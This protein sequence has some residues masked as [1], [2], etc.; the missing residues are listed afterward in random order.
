[1]AWVHC[2]ELG[3]VM[4]DGHEVRGTALRIDLAHDLVLFQPMGSQT[5]RNK[6]EI[7]LSNFWPAD[8][9]AFEKHLHA[10]N[11]GN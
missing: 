2:F 6:Q 1:V 3:T 5:H 8:R 10:K 4:L 9:L 11:V 7:P